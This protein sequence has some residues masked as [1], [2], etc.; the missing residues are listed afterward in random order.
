MESLK[1]APSSTEQPIGDDKAKELI[2][3]KRHW[4]QKELDLMR[5]WLRCRQAAAERQQEGEEGNA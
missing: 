1:S 3:L 4:N 2:G 5:E